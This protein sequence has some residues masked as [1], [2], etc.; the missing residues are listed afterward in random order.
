MAS[1][2]NIR[3]AH[4]ALLVERLEDRQLMAA[5][6]GVSLED[7]LLTI[8]GT[9]RADHVAL[10]VRGDTLQVSTR[11]LAA[12]GRLGQKQVQSFAL[13]EV[14]AIKAELGDGNDTLKIDDQ[15]RTY[16]L[17]EIFGGR[18]DDVLIGGGGIDHLDGGAGKDRLFGRQGN[19]QLTGGLDADLI[20]GG[21]GANLVLDREAVDRVL[22][23]IN[24]DFEAGVL[25]VEVGVKSAPSSVTVVTPALS[26]GV[27]VIRGTANADNINVALSGTN[28]TVA[29]Q[30]FAASGV[31]SIVIVGES[32]DDVISVSEAIKKTTYIY[33][34]HGADT[35]NGG[36]GID[37]IYGGTGNDKLYGRAGSDQI[38]GGSGTNTIVGDA[39]QVYDRVAVRTYTMNA[40]EL[41]IV[42]LTNLE[43]TSRGL[44]ALTVDT[45]IARAAYE[46]SNQM[47]SQSAV[48]GN[49]AAHNHNLWGVMLPTPSTRLE[50]AG[51]EWSSYKENIAYGYTTAAQVVTG[52]MNSAGHRANILSTDITSIGVS[53]VKNAGGTYF[54]TQNFAKP[55]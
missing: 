44:K 4:S 8:A 9:D 21:E 37:Y 36:G 6:I 33:A 23:A 31:T 19:D 20:N 18:G 30:S 5:D 45:K 55:W 28:I 12:D 53:A 17:A 54:F 52:W 39:N 41:E 7:N 35:V 50:Y 26:N 40:F 32:G 14:Q 1:K 2:P 34:G 22:A 42:R 13:S 16:S 24:A 48:I 11:S 49:V 38:W 43:R 27:L 3:R 47:A 51:F 25:P 15:F 29:G 46:H 10:E